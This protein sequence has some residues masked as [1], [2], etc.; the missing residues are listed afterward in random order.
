MIKAFQFK[1]KNDFIFFNSLK[2]FKHLRKQKRKKFKSLCY[3]LSKRLSRRKSF[4][5]N[6]FYLQSNNLWYLWKK[7]NISSKLKLKKKTII[8]LQSKFLKFLIY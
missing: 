7:N 1:I 6:K 5:V 2:H 8:T 3:R 4:N